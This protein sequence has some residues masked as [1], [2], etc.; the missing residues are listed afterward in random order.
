M[1][2]IFVSYDEFM[3]D[4]RTNRIFESFLT[5]LKAFFREAYGYSEFIHWKK[6]IYWL[7]RQ[8][9]HRILLFF[10][11]GKGKIGPKLSMKVLGLLVCLINMKLI[12]RDCQT[13]NLVKWL[14]SNQLNSL[15]D[16]LAMRLFHPYKILTIS[17]KNPQNPLLLNTLESY[18]IFH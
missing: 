5:K 8:L 14:R 13:W 18:W 7:E 12:S 15:F 4:P 16:W 10:T 1:L 3:I 6:N 17:W 11:E 9:T 2:V